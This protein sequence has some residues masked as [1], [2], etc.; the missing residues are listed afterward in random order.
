MKGIV[1]TEFL[2][3]TEVRFGYQMVDRIILKSNLPSRG[4]YTSIGDY[5]EDELFLLI[6]ALHEEAKLEKKY[7]MTLLGAKM[8]ESFI[9][10]YKNRLVAIASTTSFL[11][12]LEIYVNMLVRSMY[13]KTKVPTIEI[14]NVGMS[15]LI[16]TYYTENRI[17]EL[18]EGFIQGYLSVHQEKV[19]VHK[20]GFFVNNL[21]AY[22]FVLEK[23]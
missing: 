14:E 10:N 2:E 4:I 17:S 12:L 7:L 8:H 11:N 15:K 3:M 5:P 6:D 22:K 9:E 20:L 23:E 16:M 19:K 1:F 13:A 18:I 21:S